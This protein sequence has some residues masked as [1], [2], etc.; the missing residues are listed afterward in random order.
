MLAEVVFAVEGPFLL[1]LFLALKEVVGFEVLAGGVFGLT[2]YAVLASSGL[3]CEGAA[4]WAT[5]P[6]FEGEVQGLLMSLPVVLC[7]EGVCAESTLEDTSTT[8][9]CVLRSCSLG[10]GSPLSPTSVANG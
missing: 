1:S 7:W 5:G 6:S 4:F 3:D 9:L 10:H 2:E 8:R